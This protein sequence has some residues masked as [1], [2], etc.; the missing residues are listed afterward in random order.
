MANL[1]LKISRDIL[2]ETLPRFKEM[3]RWPFV[4]SVI[5]MFFAAESLSAKYF[6]DSHKEFEKCIT[7]V[8]KCFDDLKLKDTECIKVRL[9]PIHIFILPLP[10]LIKE[11]KE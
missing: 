10:N 9:K 11:Q 8:V 6:L 2:K 5:E 1:V 4:L 7:E 3:K